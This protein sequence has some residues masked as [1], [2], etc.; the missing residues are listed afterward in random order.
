M[1]VHYDQ[2]AD[3]LY[4]RLT[5]VPIVESDEVRPGVVLDYDAQNHIVSIE[6]RS[7]SKQLPDADF[8]RLQ[9]EVA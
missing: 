1:K 5:D 4:L 3:A 6:I 2:A 9:L 8:R 7:L